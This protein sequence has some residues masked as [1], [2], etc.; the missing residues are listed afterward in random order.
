MK[1]RSALIVG[2]VLL[3]GLMASK[4]TI[5]TSQADEKPVVSEAERV[6]FEDTLIRNLSDGLVVEVEGLAG[7]RSNLYLTR[8]GARDVLDRLSA[9]GYK[10]VRD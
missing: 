5:N 8:K 10:V 7:I 3:G 6:L 1:L 2:A 9:R 4:C